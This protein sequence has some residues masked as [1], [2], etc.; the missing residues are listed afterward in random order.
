MSLPRDKLERA[1]EF[2][3]SL[4]I[5]SRHSLEAVSRFIGFFTMPQNGIAEGGRFSIVH[6]AVAKANAP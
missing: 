1:Q 4:L 2:Q 3:N 6:Q 5:G